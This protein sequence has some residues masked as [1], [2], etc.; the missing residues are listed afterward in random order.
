M[1]A[2]RRLR[3]LLNN[4]CCTRP[5]K[6]QN[7][8]KAER[9]LRPSSITSFRSKYL[10]TKRHESRKAFETHELYITA[11]TITLMYKTS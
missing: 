3:L 11:I 6:V 7:V 8:M 5:Q 9:R 2:E 4:V 1:K 10:G